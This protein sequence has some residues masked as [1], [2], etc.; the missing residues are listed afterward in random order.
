MAP[1][2]STL[3]NHDRAI[4]MSPPLSGVPTS[5]NTL[6]GDPSITVPHSPSLSPQPPPEPVT[7]LDIQ[8]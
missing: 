7:F 1:A 8:A 6:N 4:H 3:R 5:P 2:L